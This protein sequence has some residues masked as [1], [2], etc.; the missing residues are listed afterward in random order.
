[1]AIPTH[2]G[3]TPPAATQLAP[4]NAG[5]PPTAPSATSPAVQAGQV[6]T[7][8]QADELQAPQ[9]DVATAKASVHV[10]HKSD[11]APA[12]DVDN[13][14]RTIGLRNPGDP[15]RDHDGQDWADRGGPDQGRPDPGGPDPDQHEW[16]HQVRQWDR[17]WVQYDQDWRPI[18][19]NPYQYP[20]QVVYDYQD[21]PQIV[22]IPP[23]ASAVLDVAEYGAYSFTAAVLDTV[24]QAVDVAVGSFFGGGYDPGPDLPPPPPPPPVQTYDDVPVAVDYP[25]ATYQPFL[26]NQVVDTGNDPQYGEDKLLL[27]GVTPVWGQWT[28][29]PD[30]QRQFDVHKTQQFPG[31]DTPAP[32]PLPGD[33]HLQLASTAKPG[34]PIREVIIIA[35][36]AV[37]ATLAVCG[38]IGFAMLRRRRVRPLH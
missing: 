1:M 33:Y 26:V 9:Q 4:R 12:S 31:L 34:M 24:G 10:E 27:D 5:A 8:H 30:G 35:A 6:V 7:I 2:S 38:A 28:Q 18:I 21:A 22:V 13:L 17:D 15:A 16:D 37:V 14:R 29:T 23:F 3:E 25:D 36:S 32:G 19:C 20:V 11:P